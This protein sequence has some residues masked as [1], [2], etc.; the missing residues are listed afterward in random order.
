MLVASVCVCVCVRVRV[1]ARVV[2]VHPRRPSFVRVRV[3]VQSPF[4]SARAH[5]LTSARARPLTSACALHVP[6][7]EH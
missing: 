1:G 2:A 4:H 7:Y 6:V 5:P 3:R